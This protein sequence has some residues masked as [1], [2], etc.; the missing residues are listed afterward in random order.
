MP[1]PFFG[2]QIP[3][4]RRSQMNNPFGDGNCLQLGEQ[5]DEPDLIPLSPNEQR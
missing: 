2:L 1:G 3:A 5:I 4:P